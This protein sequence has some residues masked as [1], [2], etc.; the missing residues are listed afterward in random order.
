[1]WSG[2]FSRIDLNGHWSVVLGLGDHMQC[3]AWS[4][5]ATIRPTWGVWQ[6]AVPWSRPYLE[7]VFQKC[8]CGSL[9][10]L[11]SARRCLWVRRGSLGT[12]GRV[13]GGLFRCR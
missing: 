7:L 11:S 6:R 1:M 13:L 8:A 12:P 5:P 2:A 10:R 4:S 3:I 9:S